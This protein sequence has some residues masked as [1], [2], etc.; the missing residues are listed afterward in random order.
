MRVQLLTALDR[1]GDDY[2]RDTT[3]LKYLLCPIFAKN[4][5]QQATFYELFDNYLLEI[6]RPLPKPPPPIK[7][8]HK[9][10]KWA[11]GLFALGLVALLAY[12]IYKF[13]EKRPKPD[14]RFQ[15]VAALKVGDTL[16]AIN[17]SQHIP[18]EAEMLWELLNTDGKVEKQV[19]LEREND[20]TFP[21]LSAG[22]QPN[23]LLRL[24]L[25][26]A[27]DDSVSVSYTHLTLPTKA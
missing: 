10:P 22:P 3:A 19:T 5:A 6:Q 24:T 21:I 16:R 7:W 27:P 18:Q 12:G 23:K 20:W 15:S 2:L 17:Q 13:V 9:I 4:A 8:Y 25:I 26:D 14:V 1:L 11:Y